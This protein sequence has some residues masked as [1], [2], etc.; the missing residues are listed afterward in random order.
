MSAREEQIRDLMDTYQRSLTTS[1]AALAASCYAGDGVFMPTGLP[2]ASGGE[3]EAAYRQ[4][5]Q[6]IRLD[7][8]FSIDELKVASDDSAYALTRS[9]GIQTVLATGSES[10]EA[11]REIFVFRRTTDDGWKIARYMFNK[12]E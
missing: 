10:A 6:A 8:T 11:N 2:T 3:L 12:A 9:N 1:D 4:I 5:F 7:V